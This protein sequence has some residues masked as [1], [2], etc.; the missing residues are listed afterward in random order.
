MESTYVGTNW[1]HLEC[2]RQIGS[3]MASLKVGRWWGQPTHKEATCALRA[4]SKFLPK[5]LQD[6][7]SY[8]AQQPPVPF[9]QKLSSQTAPLL[10]LPYQYTSARSASGLHFET[11][12][13]HIVLHCLPSFGCHGAANPLP[14]AYPQVMHVGVLSC[15]CKLLTPKRRPLQKGCTLVMQC[16]SLS[17]VI[18]VERKV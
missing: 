1:P 9:F 13:M 15:F 2:K 3:H 16:K 14:S 8:T 7:Y 12:H 4:F 10:V 18:N 11:A 6:S 5:G 17:Q